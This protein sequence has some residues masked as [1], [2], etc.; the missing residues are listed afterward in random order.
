[1]P[2]RQMVDSGDFVYHVLNRGAKRSRLFESS[3]DYR[4]LEQILWE[5]KV[6]ISM[7]IL[8]YCIMPNHWHLVLK[9]S[10]GKQ[11][12]QFMHWFTVTHVHRWQR[13]HET[14]GTGAVYQGPYKAIPVETETQFL[15]VCRYVERNP[16]RAR[17]VIQAQDWRWSSLWRREHVVDEMLAAWPVSRPDKWTSLVNGFEEPEL[18][19]IRAAVRRGVPCGDPGWVDQTAHTFGLHAHLN[20]TGRPKKAAKRD[21]GSLF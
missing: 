11:L 16:L 6:R 2:K 15:N 8:A 9:P 18:T 7:A 17:L 14:V 3:S 19:T 20:P 12:S 5:A 21:P 13:F 4:A 10:S 1:M